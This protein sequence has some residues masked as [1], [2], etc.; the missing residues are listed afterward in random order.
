MSLEKPEHILRKS[1]MSIDPN[2]IVVLKLLFNKN[3]V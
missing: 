2:G 3:S 1:F